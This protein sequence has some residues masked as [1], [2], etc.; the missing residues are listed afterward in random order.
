[1]MVATSSKMLVPMRQTTRHYIAQTRNLN[2]LT[3]IFLK[4]LVY[5]KKYK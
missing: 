1:M 4:F 2:I 5:F 3:D